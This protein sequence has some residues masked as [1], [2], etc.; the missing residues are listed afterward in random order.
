V[1]LRAVRALEQASDDL[2]IPLAGALGDRNWQVRRAAAEGLAGVD[3]SGTDALLAAVRDRHRD[4]AVLNAALTALV[5]A[6]QD[7]LPQVA[8]LLDSSEADVRTYGALA[9]GLLQDR[10]GVPAL[11]AA[12]DDPDANVRF[13]AIEALGR[14]RSR[15]AALPVAAVAES[16]DFAVAFAALDTLALIGEPSISPRIVPLLDDDMLHT[17]AADA[18]GRLGG[19]DVVAPL[20][21]LIARSPDAAASAAGALASLSERVDGPRA[22]GGSVADLARSVMTLQAGRHLVAAMSTATEEEACGIATVLGWLEHDGVEAAL[23][24]ALS[25]PCV[26]RIVS[27]ALVLRGARAIAPLLAALGG[28]EDDEVRKTIAATLGRI[29]APVAVPALLP[30]LDESAELSVVAA[31]ALG[32]IGVEQA[33]EPLLA[34]LDDPHAAVRQAA[35]AALHSLGPRDMPERIGSLLASSSPHARESAAKLAAYVGDDGGLEL[36]LLLAA[37]ADEA[38]RRAAVEQLAQF[39][40]ARA[41]AAIVDALERGTSSV[42]AAVIRALGL[43]SA[44]DALDR[45]LAATDDRDPWVR[46]Y[47]ARSL[48]H[49]GEERSVDALVRLATADAVP[50]VRIAAIDALIEM[51]SARGL[52]ALAPVAADPDPAVARQALLAIGQSGDARAIPALGHALA[53]GDRARV[54]AALDALAQGAPPSLVGSIAPFAGVGDPEVRERAVVVLA[55]SGGDEAVAALISAAEEPALTLE[56]VNALAS[57]SDGD[58]DRVGRGLR[59]TDIAVRCAVIESL[60]R[61]QSAHVLPLLAD[62]LHDDNE[63][64]RVAAAHALGRVDLRAARETTVG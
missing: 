2:T 21:A 19:E 48:G 51:R 5:H 1:R 13:H 22:G 8:E 54:I 33:V 16:R 34:R 53:S 12:L 4:P 40:D 27:D 45:L 29:G 38:V 60:G 46:Y 35:V 52:A 11:V 49:L 37:D 9:L 43:A 15:A 63:A 17:A 7:V 47:A 64:V 30:L 62:A 26:R 31:S 20:A 28:S 24:S 18:L 3:G 42:R 6:R 57:L 23:T 32:S 61:M 14:I 58:V 55:R 39:D 50:P 36:L 56:M 59:H 41:L 44:A 10:R 25:I